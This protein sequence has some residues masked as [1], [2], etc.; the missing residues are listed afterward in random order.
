VKTIIIWVLLIGR[1]GSDVTAWPFAAFHTHEDC[2][3]P[4]LII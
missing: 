4:A 1:H 2:E 3:I